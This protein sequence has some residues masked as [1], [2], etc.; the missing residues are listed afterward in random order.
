METQTELPFQAALLF[1][2]ALCGL[3]KLLITLILPADPWLAKPSR[4]TV[5]I[6]LSGID[7]KGRLEAFVC[8]A[9]VRLAREKEHVAD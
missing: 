7:L 1:C 3:L 8:S 4:S 2:L 5:S 6:L 9:F